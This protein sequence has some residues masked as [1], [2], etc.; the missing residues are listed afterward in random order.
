M[1]P[2]MLNIIIFRG[3]TND[4]ARTPLSLPRPRPSQN[5]ELMF[6]ACETYDKT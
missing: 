2:T 1:L 6:D 4:D 3:F 5:T